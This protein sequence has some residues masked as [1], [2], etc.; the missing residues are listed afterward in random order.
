VRL[1]YAKFTSFI[2]RLQGVVPT[3]VE[4]E[5]E[6]EEVES[7]EE[8]SPSSALD[9]EDDETL[10]ALFEGA[11][12]APLDGAACALTLRPKIATITHCILTFNPFNELSLV[13]LNMSPPRNTDSI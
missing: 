4:I 7:L 13:L 11:D 1:K 6:L 5:L 10:A 3:L 9:A 12:E 2:I 8:P